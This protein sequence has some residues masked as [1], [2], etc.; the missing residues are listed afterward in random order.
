[1]TPEHY[2]INSEHTKQSYIKRICDWYEEHRYLTCDKPRFGADRSLGQN[3][4]FHVWLTELAA[5][6]ADC[7]K[8]SVTDGM[9]EGMKRHVK[10]MCYQSNGW[11]FM[12]H[13]VTCPETGDEKTD[14]R[15]SAKWLQPEAFQVLTWMQAHYEF[16]H[17]ITLESKGEYNQL[18]KSQVA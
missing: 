15:S 5:H 13:K 8:K 16:E 3:S 10:R 6:F 2:V 14:F 1:M 4:L 12:V 7:S 18:Q 17:Q 11:Q 9:I